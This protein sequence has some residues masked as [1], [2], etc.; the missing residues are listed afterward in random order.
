MSVLDGIT[1]KV[2]TRVTNG[3]EVNKLLSVIS[4]E[5]LQNL[6]ARIK[7]SLTFSIIIDESTDNSMI[8]Q[9]TVNCVCGK[10]CKSCKIFRFITFN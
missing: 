1:A 5:I 2:P 10:W 7:K 9:L 3:V 4:N 8:E 6:L